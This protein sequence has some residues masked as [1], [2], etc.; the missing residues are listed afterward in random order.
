AN[1]SQ[2]AAQTRLEIAIQRREEA[3]LNSEREQGA[4]LTPERNNQAIESF[5][6]Q[7]TPSAGFSQ[8]A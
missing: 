2:M 6:S 5:T 1:A 7:D 4:A 3:Q 8:F